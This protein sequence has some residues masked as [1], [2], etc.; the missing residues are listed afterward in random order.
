[1]LEAA[2]SSS[3]E[4]AAEKSRNH[5]HRGRAAL[6]A[7][8]SRFTIEQRF[9]ACAH[10]SPM[11]VLRFL[12]LLSMAVWLGGLIFFPILAQ[13][14]FSVLPSTHLAGLVVRNYLVKLH[15]M[16]FASGLVFLPSSSIYNRIVFGRTR[17]FGLSHI[18]VIIMLALTAISQFRIIPRMDNLRASAEEMGSLAKSA[19]PAIR[20]PTRVV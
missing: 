4:H 5:C 17:A 20:F 2:R 10:D 6:P 11:N 9:R 12:M 8:R 1:M 13:T 14:S 7:P 19:P 16:A 18:L 3:L 15:C